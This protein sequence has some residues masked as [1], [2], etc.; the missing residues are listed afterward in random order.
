VD[1]LGPFVEWVPVCPEVELGLGTPRESIRLERRRGD[2]RLRAPRSGADHTENMRAY[3]RQRVAALGKEGLCGYVLKKDSPSCG[4]ERVRIYGENGPPSR[5]GRG[6]FAEELVARLPGL[7]VEEEGRLAD[8]G[9]RE[10][11]VI[12]LFA[13]RRVRDLF[14]ERWT[15]SGLVG[16]HT[17]H[18]LLLLAHSPSA[19][20]S[21]GRLVAGAR[22]TSREHL[23]DRY[24]LGLM[25][26]LSRSVTRSR[27][28]NALQHALGFFSRD[29]SV[30]ERQELL[31]VIDDHRK[32]LLPLVVPITLLRHHV[33]RLGVTYLQGQVYLEPHPKELM[34]RNH[35]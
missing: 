20:A 16:F 29:L 19:Y 28:T 4:L 25:E 35:V 18:K 17:A 8:P 32:G 13:Y 24:T 5:T 31:G 6:L 11:F 22:R 23:R 14:A 30:P 15:V 7:P 34:L 33:H 26:A 10:S 3:A 27:H 21:L 1:S 2:V 12:R 9:L